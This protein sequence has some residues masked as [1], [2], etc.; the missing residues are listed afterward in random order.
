LLINKLELKQKRFEKA[1]SIK[2]GAS[3]KLSKKVW[4]SKK[5][6]KARILV[7]YRTIPTFGQSP[8]DLWLYDVVR[9][10]SKIE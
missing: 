4:D 8:K 3:V 5:L 6:S 9:R 10:Y 1:V 7:P 2:R